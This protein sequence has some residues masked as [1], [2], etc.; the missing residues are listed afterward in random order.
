VPFFSFLQEIVPCFHPY[1]WFLAAE[2]LPQTAKLWCFSRKTSQNLTKRY[3]FFLS[4]LWQAG[5]G[6]GGCLFAKF[7]AFLCKT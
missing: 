5:A 6:Q 3:C 1:P 4:Q 7:A 2:K